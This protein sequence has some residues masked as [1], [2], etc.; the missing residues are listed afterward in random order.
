[1]PTATINLLD[2][3]KSIAI[4]GYQ[5]HE[6]LEIFHL[7]WS[8]EPNALD[9]LTLDEALEGK[10]IEISELTSAGHVPNIKI[11]NHSDRMVFLLA[12][13]QLVGC[14]QNRVL[15]ASIMVPARTEI[16]LPVTCVESGRWGYQSSAFSSAH[17]SSH[18]QLRAMMDWQV[19]SSYKV[20]GA[21]RSDQA[22]VWGEVS[23]KLN[24]MGSRSPSS[25]LQAVYRDYGHRLEDFSNRLPAPEEHH[26]AVFA[27]AGKI[28]G[29]DLFDS[30][31]TLRKL[32][33]KLV[34]SCAV[35]AFESSRDARSISTQEVAAWL[36]RSAG[37]QQSVFTSPGIGQNVRL[38]A[39]ELFGAALMVEDH[40]VHLELFRYVEGLHGRLRS[41]EPRREVGSERPATATQEP[42]QNPPAPTGN[43]LYRI[44]RRKPSA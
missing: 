19:T 7:R 6:A 41:A 26:G 29:A 11:N 24:A 8:V 3:L 21:P 31:D 16:P 15:N 36:E 40:P 28:S 39:G 35:D 25:E 33:P 37:A 4:D 18:H 42:A 30:P 17:S 22:A 43:W 5:Q 10:W 12:G 44:L 2:S 13:E 20:A 32:W 23:R 27:I 34:R 9:Y 14:K 1:M 38:Q